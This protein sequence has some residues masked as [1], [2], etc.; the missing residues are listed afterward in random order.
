MEHLIASSKTL[1][2]GLKEI[3]KVA[4]K[5]SIKCPIL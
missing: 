4:I 2:I 5:Y 3:L 1:S